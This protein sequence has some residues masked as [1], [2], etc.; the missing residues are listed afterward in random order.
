[1]RIVLGIS[2]ASGAPYARRAMEFLSGPG[3]RAGKHHED[4][5]IRECA[6]PHTGHD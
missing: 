3:R 1:M 5:G 4:C 2:G 6:D